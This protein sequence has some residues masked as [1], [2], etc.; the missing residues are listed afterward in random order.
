M[1]FTSL[2]DNRA[3]I[4]ERGALT[5]RDVIRL[6]LAAPGVRSIKWTNG[7]TV[8]ADGAGG[9]ILLRYGVSGQSYSDRIT[10]H[11]TPCHYGGERLFL[12]CPKCDKARMAVYAAAPFACRVC[13]RLAYP[14]ESAPP[15]FRAYDTGQD[16]AHK[17][18]GRF[19]CL[20]EPFPERPKGMHRATYER[21]RAKWAALTSPARAFADAH[22]GTDAKGIEQCRAAGA[23]YRAERE[24]Q[25]TR[26]VDR[27]ADYIAAYWDDKPTPLRRVPTV[28]LDR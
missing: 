8:T 20:D 25:E 27:V 14:S 13:H 9:S 6:N 5:V 2:T 23:S 19:V 24:A 21:K 3:A 17:L 4:T 28:E 11:W 7:N 15:L 22:L 18:A 12:I 1:T 26:K 10:L 16:I